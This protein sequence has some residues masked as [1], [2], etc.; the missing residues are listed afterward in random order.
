MLVNYI[1]TKKLLTGIMTIRKLILAGSKWKKPI[2]SMALML[3]D[4]NNKKN[5]LW[6]KYQSLAN[7]NKKYIYPNTIRTLVDQITKLLLLQLIKITKNPIPESP[8]HALRPTLQLSNSTKN[9]I[10]SSHGPLNGQNKNSINLLLLKRWMTI[11]SSNNSMSTSKTVTVF[12]F[13]RV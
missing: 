2:Q 12:L 3:W 4:L 10:I 7:S 6:I 9:K 5:L 13:F 8:C 1:V 11:I